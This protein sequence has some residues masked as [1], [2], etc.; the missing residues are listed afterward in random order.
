M[1]EVKISVK[2]RRQMHPA[3]IADLVCIGECLVLAGRKLS[4]GLR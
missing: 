4:G 3:G 1:K 2:F